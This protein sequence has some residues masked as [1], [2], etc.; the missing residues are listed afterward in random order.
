MSRPAA[1]RNYRLIS[2]GQTGVDRAALDAALEVGVPCGGWCPHGRRAENG[3]I[4]AHYPLTE[5]TSADYR[6]R[7]ERNVVEADGTLILARGALRGGT[8]LTKRLTRQ[9]GK[10]CLVI[11]LRRQPQVEPIV[12]WMHRHGLRTVN[13]AGPRESHSAGIEHQA[14][15]LLVSL[16]RALGQGRCG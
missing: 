4:P 2:G 11:D 6:E 7:T 1:V 5:T 16:L 10:P 9:H 3:P 8:A 15:R 14:R 13:V 12:A